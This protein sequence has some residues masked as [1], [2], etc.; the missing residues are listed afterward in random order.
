MAE[1]LAW[2][3]ALVHT[4]AT[5]SEN[6]T[7]EAAAIAVTNYLQELADDRKANPKGDVVTHVVQAKINDVPLTKQGDHW[8]SLSAVP[9]RSRHGHGYDGMVFSLPC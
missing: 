2:E 5:A 9:G 4:G 1:F 6:M 3:T 8:D 7:M